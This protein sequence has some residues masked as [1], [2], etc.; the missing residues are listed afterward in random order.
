MFAE[1]SVCT[2][3][4]F[5]VYTVQYELNTAYTGIYSRIPA[6]FDKFKH[7]YLCTLQTHKDFKG[8]VVNCTLPYLL[9][10]SLEITL[11]VPLS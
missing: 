2:L 10:G 1:Y 3:P 5:S 7:T 11:T 8:T 4:V 6:G 9:G